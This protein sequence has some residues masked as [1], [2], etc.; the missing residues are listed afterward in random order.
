MSHMF[1]PG[2]DDEIIHLS[3]SVHVFEELN[4]KLWTTSHS[5]ESVLLG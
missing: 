3:L 5:G 2:K 1:R 4:R